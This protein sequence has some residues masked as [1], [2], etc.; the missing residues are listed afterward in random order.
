MESVDLDTAKWL[1]TANSKQVCA[2]VGRELAAGVDALKLAEQLARNTAFSGRQRSATIQL[3]HVRAK[4][5]NR[6]PDAEQMFFTKDALE[7][8]SDPLVAKWRAE[9][10]LARFNKMNGATPKRV[11]DLCAGV[12]GDAEY[13][14]RLG[15]PLTCVEI[16]PVRALF[17]SHNLEV[18]G[19][20]ATVTVADARTITTGPTDAVFADPARRHNGQRIT[21]LAAY[22]PSVPLLLERHQTAGVVAIAV[23]PGV[24]GDDPSLPPSTEVAYLDVAGHL[25]EDV[26]WGGSATHVSGQQATAVL[27]PELLTL[28]RQRLISQVEVEQA[29]TGWLISMRPAAVRARVHDLLAAKIDARRVAQ[30][31][32]VFHATEQP[33]QSP[34]YHA[35]QITAVTSAQ[36]K[37]IRRCLNELEERP[38][39][40]VLHGADVDVTQLWQR[41][42][43]PKRGPQGW[44]VEVIRR[45]HDSI[46]VITDARG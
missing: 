21:S 20:Q 46:A 25:S 29:V 34:W 2:D 4:A 30:H 16:D 17:L 36:P 32:A 13:L 11:L 28:S 10:L 39:E 37:Q 12:G 33:P 8:L 6:Y 22:K 18:M 42:G 3:A 15:A 23:A 44:R 9:D 27:L 26:L 5:A 1:F 35:R 40:I 38:V 19:V 31:R 7:Q 43:A 45:D 41:L 24:D 14:S